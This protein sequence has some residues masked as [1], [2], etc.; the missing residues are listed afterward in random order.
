MQATGQKAE[1]STVGIVY[2]EKN[3]V[4]MAYLS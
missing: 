3:T 2:K 1:V 4:S